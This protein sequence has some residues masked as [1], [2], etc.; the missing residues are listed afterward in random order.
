M[1]DKI[2]EQCNLHLQKPPFVQGGLF[3]RF[4]NA[5]KNKS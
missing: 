3:D 1:V 5:G 4:V 2:N